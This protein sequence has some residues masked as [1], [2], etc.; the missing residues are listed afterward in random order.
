MDKEKFSP[1]VEAMRKVVRGGGAA[2]RQ[3]VDSVADDKGKLR[4]IAEASLDGLRAT[5][6]GINDN[7]HV[8]ISHAWDLHGDLFNDLAGAKSPK[9]L[10]GVITNGAGTIV[11]LSGLVSDHPQQLRAV[12]EA[13]LATLDTAFSGVSPAK[14]PI[15]KILNDLRAELAA[16]S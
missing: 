12:A 10:R 15:Y 11:Q 8:V 14:V 2:I 16:I 5:L 7:P 4:A 3:L 1:E 9:T 13:M 6:S